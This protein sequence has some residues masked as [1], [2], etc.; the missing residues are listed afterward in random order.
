MIGY[1][2]RRLAEC[3]RVGAL[4]GKDEIRSSFGVDE[5]LAISIITMRDG[6]AR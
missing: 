5:G 2:E 1:F 3:D 6:A 4:V